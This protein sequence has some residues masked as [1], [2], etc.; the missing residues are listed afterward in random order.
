MG[1]FIELESNNGK[2]CRFKLEYAPYV[3]NRKNFLKS[4]TC[5]NRI[6][7]PC[8]TNKKELEEAIK[9]VSENQIWDFG[10]E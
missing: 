4:H 5:F 8:Y 6:D 1:G 7:L 2:L 9:F 10:M 3:K